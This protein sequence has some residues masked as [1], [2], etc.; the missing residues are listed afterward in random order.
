M[1]TL[2]SLIGAGLLLGLGLG[3]GGGA[4]ATTTAAPPAA[5]TGFTYT[6]PTG[7]GWRLVRNPASTRTRLVLD[8]VGPSGLM[9]RGAAFNLRAPQGIRFGRF[10][11]GLGVEDAGVYELLNQDT[12]GDP[13]EPVLKGAGVK[14]GNVLT[15]G[16]FQK[17]RR[18]SAKDSGGPLFRVALEFDATAKVNAGG[19]L[20]LTALKARYIAE[21]IGAFSVNPTV[22]MAAKAHTQDFSLAVGTLRAE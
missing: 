1:R 5:A 6:D 22:E 10:A 8:L 2:F 12:T 15:V 7:T 18:L 17:D 9:T 14:A 4:A 3:C 16:L 20:P 13:L 19:V 21:D 11:D